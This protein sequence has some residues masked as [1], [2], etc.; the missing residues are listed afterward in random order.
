MCLQDINVRLKE[1]IWQKLQFGE[2]EGNFYDGSISASYS[3]VSISHP[4]LGGCVQSFIYPVDRLVAPSR[5]FGTG[6]SL[7]KRDKH[8]P[9]SVRAMT[10]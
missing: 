10:K 7:V 1:H 8:G 9:C 2:E 5:M 4:G 3:V 6:D